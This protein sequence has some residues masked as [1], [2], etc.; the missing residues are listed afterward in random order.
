MYI[1]SSYFIIFVHNICSFKSFLAVK[2]I[3][4]IGLLEPINVPTQLKS[5]P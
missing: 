3:D 1:E 4:S 5:W 2:S